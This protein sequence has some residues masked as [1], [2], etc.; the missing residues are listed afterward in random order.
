MFRI[1]MPGI[2][3][4]FSA[5]Y[6]NY[7]SINEAQTG[8]KTHWGAPP[9]AGAGWVCILVSKSWPLDIIES[10]ENSYSLQ[11]ERTAFQQFSN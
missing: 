4:G 9:G 3:N 2:L 8:L 10:F 6:A 7:L 11:M 5:F 1:A